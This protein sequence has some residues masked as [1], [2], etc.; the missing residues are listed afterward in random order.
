MVWL[1]SLSNFHAQ[2]VIG[3]AFCKSCN[4][5]FVG[6]QCGSHYG[7]KCNSNNLHNFALSNFM[8][9]AYLEGL[10][11]VDDNQQLG[12]CIW[13]HFKCIWR[14]GKEYDILWCFAYLLKQNLKPCQILLRLILG[15][16]WTNMEAQEYFVLQF[17]LNFYLERENG[18]NQGF[19]SFSFFLFKSF[20]LVHI[21]VKCKCNVY[22][23]K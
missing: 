6:R 9:K 5:N 7:T 23:A 19:D 15:T 20:L 22:D 18:P 21:L 11:K 2:H 14:M 10:S 12:V 16:S 3:F 4:C 1:E 8:N 17:L 13:K